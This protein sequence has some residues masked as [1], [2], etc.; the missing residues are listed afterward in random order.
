MPTRETYP[1]AE[2][3]YE[4]LG[5]LLDTYQLSDQLVADSL[6]LFAK[7]GVHIACSEGCS[8]CCK[9]P[10][11]PVT[12]LEMR[13]LSWYA[14]EILSGEI[15]QSVKH[16]LLCHKDTAECPFLVN[17]VCS[18]YPVRP[19]ICRQ[20]YVKNTVCG[21]EEDILHSRPND[22]VLPNPSMA[23]AT[24]MKLLEFF[25]IHSR[26][27]KERAFKSGVLAQNTR[28]MHEHKLSVIAETI[29]KF[30]AQ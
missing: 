27:K 8:N 16:R 23:R 6:K 18:V 19:I 14:S 15:R 17:N 10:T 12:E 26:L 21:E 9:R 30:D 13:G 24:S 4:W 29:E 22:I 11:V 2:K 7:N 25:G 3:K 20:F 28:P 5:L 1:E